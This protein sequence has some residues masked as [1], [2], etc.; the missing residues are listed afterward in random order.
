[1]PS[2]LTAARRGVASRRAARAQRRVTTK[3][4]AA[5]SIFGFGVS[6]LMLGGFA[7]LQ[8]EHGLDQAGHSGG[9]SRWPKL[10]LTSRSAV[11][12]PVGEARK[13]FGESGHLD[14]IAQLVALPWAS[15]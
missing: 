7:V 5:K 4:L 14:W 15:T 13:A 10:D 9:T 3:G 6:K 2:E 1:M 12:A 8:G 11:G